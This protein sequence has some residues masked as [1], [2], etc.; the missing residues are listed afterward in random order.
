MTA[1]L[2]PDL[3]YPEWLALKERAER[4]AQ[5]AELAAKIF[6]AALLAATVA[7]S[8]VLLGTAP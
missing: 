1:P 6:L 8:L 3:S 7:C 5:R 2:P 4:R